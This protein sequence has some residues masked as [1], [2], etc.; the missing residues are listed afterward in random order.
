VIQTG[1]NC[2]KTNKVAGKSSTTGP[3]TYRVIVGG[4]QVYE[5]SNETAASTVASRFDNATV[6][7][8]GKTS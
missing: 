5:S 3:N 6:L 1:C 2:N 7:E 4:R 8:P